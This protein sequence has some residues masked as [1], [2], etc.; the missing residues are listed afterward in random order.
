MLL[1]KFRPYEALPSLV[2]QFFSR[3]WD[4]DFRSSNGNFTMPAVNIS[5]TDDQFTVELAA[6]GLNK[7]D[8]KITVDN[9]YLTI[10]ATQE[11]KSDE[12]SSNGQFRRMEFNYRN[13]KRTFTLPEEVN[14]DKI[15]SRYENGVLRLELPKKDEAKPRPVR[16]IKVS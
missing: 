1:T 14:A 9:G 13:F 5:E 7:N 15:A 2:D 10:E 8:F 16:E 12:T 3:F 11:Q 4:E 6:P